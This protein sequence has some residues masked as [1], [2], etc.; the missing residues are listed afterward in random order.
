MKYSTDIQMFDFHN[1]EVRVLTDDNGEPWFVGKDVTTILGYSDT[2]GA[3]KKHVEDV[4]KQNCQNDSFE[5]P[6]GMTIIN[7]SGLYSLIFASKLAYAKEFKRWVTGEVL[8]SI[9]KHG[10]YLVGQE[11]MTPEEMVAASMRYLESKIAE[12]RKQLEEQAPK[13]LF[14]DTVS[15]AANSIT[16]GVLAKILKQK[17]VPDM[18]QNRLFTKL[19]EDGFLCKQRGENWNMPTQYAMERGLFNVKER[20]VANPDGSVRVTRTTM[21]TGRGQIFFV[22]KYANQPVTAE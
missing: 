5:S 13:V 2:Y 8:P 9:R 15:G 21:V 14:A 6:R 20:T 12:Q 10:G 19:R 17:G 18:G 7:E 22:N 1:H 16:V 3:L 11:R 4:D